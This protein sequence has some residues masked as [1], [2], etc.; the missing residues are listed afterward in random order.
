MCNS[1]VRPTNDNPTPTHYPLPLPIKLS[2]L[3]L[4]LIQP[5]FA[6]GFYL[7]KCIV[8]KLLKPEPFKSIG[9]ITWMILVARPLM[10][11]NRYIYMVKN[12]IIKYGNCDLSLPQNHDSMDNSQKIN[13]LTNS[14]YGKT[15]A[16]K[17]IRNPTSYVCKHSHG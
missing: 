2:S 17:C 11:D 6:V 4:T 16:H 14:S 15:S 12:G 7:K 1:C 3:H 10:L 8:G 5:V 9:I 13:Y